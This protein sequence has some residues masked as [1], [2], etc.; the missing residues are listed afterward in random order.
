[1]SNRV[2]FDFSINTI[3]FPY[4]SD[5]ERAKTITEITIPEGVT[6]IGGA[7]FPMYGKLQTIIFPSTLKKLPRGSFI[8]CNSLKSNHTMA[9][10]HFSIE[11]SKSHILVYVKALDRYFMNHSRYCAYELFEDT[12]LID[13]GFYDELK[14]FVL[15]TQKGSLGYF[16][17]CELIQ[18]RDRIFENERAIVAHK[19]STRDSLKIVV[20]F[21]GTCVANEFPYKI[22]IGAGKVLREL[23]AKGHKIILYTVRDNSKLG[24]YLRSAIEWFMDNGIDLYGVQK[25]PIQGIAT[26]SPK[27]NGDLFIDD[28]GLGIPLK[29]DLA[30][31]DKP[32]VD[33]QR[34]RELLVER[35]TLDEEVVEYDGDMSLKGKDVCVVN[36]VP[37]YVSKLIT[38]GN[39]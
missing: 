16:D 3:T 10:K 7:G 29:I 32:F 27:P 20:D 22:D 13:E 35:G 24:G 33:W 28:R 31:S 37:I 9:V 36:H 21:D 12:I 30:I 17:I 5:S 14:E 2:D 26:K 1:M 15:E 25:C 19:L 4:A 8:G 23:V 39:D 34:V 18:R 6:E 38:N 11:Y